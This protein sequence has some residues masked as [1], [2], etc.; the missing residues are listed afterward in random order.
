[1]PN[2]VDNEILYNVISLAG[3]HSPG[4]VTLSGHNRKI[5]WNINA[6]Y[7]LDGA[8][9]TFR[10]M[11]PIEF[12]ASFYLVKDFAQGIDDY[13]A[14]DN[15][16]P[17]IDATLAGAKPHAVAIYHPDLIEND[18][19]FVCKAEIGGRVYDGKGGC[20]IAVKFQEYRAPKKK[21]GA[22]VPKPENDPNAA[23][24]AEVA[25][26]TARYQATPWQ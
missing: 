17:I 6:G 8:T 14:W 18:I 24:K 23:L 16:R 21:S 20:T 3:Q 12:T 2:V 9:I 10:N 13:T 15:F 26:L 11:P 22:P 19:K 5:N 1:M 7:A 4:K 25:S